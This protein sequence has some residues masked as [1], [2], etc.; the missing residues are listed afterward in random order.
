[1]LASQSIR[2][3]AIVGAAA[4][5]CAIFSAIF[6]NESGSLCLPP[7]A[8]GLAPTPNALTGIYQG[9][10]TDLPVLEALVAAAGSPAPSKTYKATIPISDLTPP[11]E[12]GA[13]CHSKK[14]ALFVEVAVSTLLSV[15]VGFWVL[16]KRG[17]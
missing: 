7:K 1:V 14:A 17:G 15:A 10:S 16:R 9:V 4:T 6:L 11:D 3:L 2:L 8:L 12:I 5:A 13:Y